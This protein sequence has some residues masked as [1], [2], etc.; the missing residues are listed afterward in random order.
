MKQKTSI[1]IVEDEAIIAKDLSFMLS[2]LG[3]HIVGTAY[4]ADDALDILEHIQVDLI[5]LDINIEGEK[6]GIQLAEIVNAKY[7][8]PFIYLTSFSDKATVSRAKSTEPIGY[9]VK[10]VV[11]QDLMTTIEIS[12]HQY[13]TRQSKAKVLQSSDDIF[14][15]EGYAFYKIKIG[16]ILYVE[17]N[18]N[19]AFI[20]TQAKR[21]LL[22]QTLKNVESRLDTAMFKRSHRS[23][24][25]NLD[26]ISKI[27]DGLLYI[28]EQPI[29]I[30]KSHR[31]ALIESLAFL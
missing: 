19:Y 6:D 31:K 27:E 30:S 11:E 1:L 4:T 25:V 15:K 26:K 24:L 20:H 16:D 13:N 8:V 3:Y 21:Y 17:A 23:Y 10:P 29:P 22:S 9:L 14:V 28:G 12:L 7:K 18:D 2:D 5:M